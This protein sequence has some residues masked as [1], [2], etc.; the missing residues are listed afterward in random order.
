MEVWF[1]NI[2]TKKQN[3]EATPTN[4]IQNWTEK[5]FIMV[6]AKIPDFAQFFRHPEGIKLLITLAN[7]V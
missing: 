5:A 6:V 4:F 2:L 3:K 7:F 1:G